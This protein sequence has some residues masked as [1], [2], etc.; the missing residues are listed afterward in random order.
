MK[1]YR[2]AMERILDQ[3]ENDAIITNSKHRAG[4]FFRKVRYVLSLWAERV[5]KILRERGSNPM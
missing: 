1:V 2:S 3:Q 4:T 5:K